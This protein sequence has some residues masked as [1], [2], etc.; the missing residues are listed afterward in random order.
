M[1][2]V[3]KLT[4]V[5]SAYCYENGAIRDCTLNEKNVITTEYGDLIPKY[6]DEEVRRKTNH[7]VSFY[8][9]GTIKS[10]S[11]E[12]Q[13][14]IKTP[15]GTFPAELVTFYESG[16]LKRIFPLNGQISGYWTEEDEEKLCDSYQFYF[17]FGNFKTKIINLYF[18]ESGSLKGM[19]LWPG[20]F[21]ILK[22][23]LGLMP[24]RTGFSL[25][26][27]GKLESVEPAY[28]FTIETPI[29]YVDV[30]DENALGMS[31]DNNNSLCFDKK[32]HI[33]SLVTSRSKIAVFNKDGSLDVI[34]PSVKPD[35]LEDNSLIMEPLKISFEGH[36]VKFEND[37][38]RVYDLYT[39]RFTISNSDVPE[40]AAR[41]TCGDCAS[42]KLCG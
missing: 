28:E 26:E 42:C 27:D 41:S 10:I 29:G 13:A 38:I 20:E 39:S 7:S 17:P 9:S 15:L 12:K 35:P 30:F 22:T 21:V 24:V 4:G 3:K 40:A 25:Y 6:G 5:T 37:K 11:L 36:Y 16:A 8:Q 33:K 18:Y 32:G 1:E 19:T 31:G 34:E 14:G 2:I 23:N